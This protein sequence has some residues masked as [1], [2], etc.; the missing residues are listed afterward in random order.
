M[1]LKSISIDW[2]EKTGRFFSGKGK[3]KV[4]YDNSVACDWK[5]GPEE[6]M[7]SANDLLKSHGLEIIHLDDSSDTPSFIVEPLKGKQNPPDV[8]L[9]VEEIGAILD[10]LEHVQEL[11]GDSTGFS[12]REWKQ[13]QKELDKREELIKKLRKEWKNGRKRSSKAR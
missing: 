12:K 4:Y 2:E 1:A 13:V 5:E 8:R 7:E 11:H 6:V 3:N 9:T 10:D